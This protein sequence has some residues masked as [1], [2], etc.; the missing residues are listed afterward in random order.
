[1][2]YINEDGPKAA[3]SFDAHGSD[4]VLVQLWDEGK[5]VDWCRCSIAQARYAARTGRVP[6][7][8]ADDKFRL[9]DWVSKREVDP[10]LDAS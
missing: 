8:Q 4:T 7:M 6:S 10:F 9:V 5:W 3:P 1:M 2:I